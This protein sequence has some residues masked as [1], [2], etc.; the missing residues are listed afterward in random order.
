M[1]V[2]PRNATLMTPTNVSGPRGLPSTRVSSVAETFVEFTEGNAGVSFDSSAFKSSENTDAGF[3]RE[4]SND[5]PLSQPGIINPPNYV[6]GTMLQ[7]IDA[8][9]ALSDNNH[10]GLGFSVPYVGLFAKAIEIYE[11][12]V[13]IFNGET[14]I[15]GTSFSMV[16]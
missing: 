11:N 14:A 4:K 8:P 6:F 5:Q 13:R 10:A 9:K 3:G 1:A 12:N 15:R 7:G 2:I 16:L